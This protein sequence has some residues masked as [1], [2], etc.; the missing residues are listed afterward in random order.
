MAGRGSGFSGGAKFQ[1]RMAR[2]ARTFHDDEVANGLYRWA[3][4]V[5][6]MSKAEYVPVD[7]GNLSSTG[8]VEPPE[9]SGRKVRV[10]LVYGGPAAPYALAVHEHPSR[11][12][13][14]SWRGV[15]V[16]FNPAG[17]GPKYLE[18]PLM[19]KVRT[20]RSELAELIRLDRAAR[21]A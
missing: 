8:H 9:R 11:H 16:T 19:L 7:L 14:P 17:R 1:A 20:A 21:R 6:G 4:G 3:E 12:S 15:A 2:I 10:R 13:P 18:R 5:M